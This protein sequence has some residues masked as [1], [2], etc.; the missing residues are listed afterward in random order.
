MKQFHIKKDQDSIFHFNTMKVVDRKRLRPMDKMQS[1]MYK[2]GNEI[3]E[4]EKPDKLNCFLQKI[5][6]NIYVYLS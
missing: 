5:L 6:I 1:S 2:Q 4:I 3:E